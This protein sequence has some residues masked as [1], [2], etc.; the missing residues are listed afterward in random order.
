MSF[1]TSLLALALASTP[2]ELEARASRHLLLEFER[3]GRAAPAPD[4]ALTRAARALAAHTL[5]TSAAEAADL[6]VL[7]QAVSDAS[8][9]DPIPRALVVRGSPHEEPL[10]SLLARTDLPVEP[11]THAGV[12]AAV[13]GNSAALVVLLAQRK[14]ELSPFPRSLPAPG[15]E[16][17]LCAQLPPHLRTAELYVTR[18]SGGVEK[19]PAPAS[20]EGRF[21]G[22][23]GFPTLGQHTVELIVR[24]ERGPEV[25]AMFF[26]Q[27]GAPSARGAR[28]VFKE[29]TTPG[30]A[31][32]AIVERV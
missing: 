13:S 7:T 31:R 16:K 12:G 20:G 22:R 29:P 10:K 2:A 14:A 1:A 19:L 21:C 5:A 17:T 4:P 6:L 24:G 15:V 8:G 9:F 3:V 26:V 25:A 30:A 18:P 28:T 32:A 27:V 23:L 11:A